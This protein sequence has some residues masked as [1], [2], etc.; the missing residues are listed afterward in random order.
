MWLHFLHLSTLVVV[1]LARPNT[2]GNRPCQGPVVRGT[3]NSNIQ[4]W[5]F[6]HD[7]QSCVKFMW[8]G[9]GGND[10]NRFD[11]EQLCLLKC[12]QYKG[13][14]CGYQCNLPENFDGV[15]KP[16]WRFTDVCKAARN[17]Q[18]LFQGTRP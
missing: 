15:V 16:G 14:L 4:K 7:R 12:Q 1:I 5:A 6:N 8:S 10:N 17:K 3:C 11:N 2:N 18:D 13:R 9:C